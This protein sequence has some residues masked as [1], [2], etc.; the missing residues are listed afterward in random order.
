MEGLMMAK[1]F[2]Q[3]TQVCQSLRWTFWFLASKHCRLYHN[4]VSQNL[5]SEL[6]DDLKHQDP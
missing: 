1:V 3:K 2:H 5:C 6:P 4:M